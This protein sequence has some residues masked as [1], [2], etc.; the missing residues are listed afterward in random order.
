MGMT[1]TQSDNF[2]TIPS[3]LDNPNRIGARKTKCV[4][5]RPL[6]ADCP[7]CPHGTR[8]R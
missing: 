2:A 5:G 8:T 6:T 7:T 4:H 1:T 3:I